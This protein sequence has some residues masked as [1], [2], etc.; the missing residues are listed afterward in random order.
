M[1]A[2]IIFT[3]AQSFPIQITKVGV[4]DR[5]RVLQTFYKES[6]TVR[7]LDAMK[8]SIQ[9]EIL[10]INDEIKS[11]EERKLNA[12][13]RGDETEALKLDNVIFSRKQYLN[14]YVRT[15]NNQLIAR[16]KNLSQDVSFAKELIEVIEFVGE[17]QGC[18]LVLDVST[19]GLMW[20]NYE[21]D[22][23]DQVLQ[24]IQSQY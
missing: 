22:I 15:K 10:R 1:A 8:E 19:P 20:F 16:E 2:L 3:V 7:E 18:S 4:I 21:V 9:S 12:E 24:R 17:S 5:T 11:F 14:E 6:Q 13:N 23:T